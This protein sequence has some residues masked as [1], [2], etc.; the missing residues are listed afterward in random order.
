MDDFNRTMDRHGHD[1]QASAVQK[2]T[3]SP[4]VRLPQ[5][6]H[7]V[8]RPLKESAKEGTE[9]AKT[10]DNDDWAKVGAKTSIARIV[11]APIG[12]AHR[13]AKHVLHQIRRHTPLLRVST[14]PGQHLGFALGHVDRKP[15]FALHLSHR[16]DLCETLGQQLDDLYVD[17]IDVLS[18]AVQLADG[19][20]SHVFEDPERLF[21]G[22]LSTAPGTTET[23]KLSVSLRRWPRAAVRLT[24]GIGPQPQK[25]VRR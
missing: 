4:P 10:A 19:S 22:K 7:L 23:P 6:T 17:G 18:E 5:A 13:S 11:L 25:T 2:L 24:A 3:R 9:L 15:Q 1:D 12:L 20:M 14:S 21:G 8:A 16:A